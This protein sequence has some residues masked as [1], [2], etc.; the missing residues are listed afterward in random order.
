MAQE[1]ENKRTREVAGTQYV[2]P[3]P[4]I[5]HQ[6]PCRILAREANKATERITAV[7]AS[8]CPLAFPFSLSLVLLISNGNSNPYEGSHGQGRDGRQDVWDTPCRFY[9]YDDRSILTSVAPRRVVT[10]VEMPPAGHGPQRQPALALLPERKIARYARSMRCG[11]M[12]CQ[13]CLSVNAPVLSINRP[14]RNGASSPPARLKLA[15]TWA[16]L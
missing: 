7:A 16:I 10:N 11:P 3:S 5:E 13:R 15:E 12:T 4:G 2:A 8:L 1:R 14:I 6:H 9:F